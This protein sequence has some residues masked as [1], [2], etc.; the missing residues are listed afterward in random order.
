MVAVPHQPL[1]LLDVAGSSC[2]FHHAESGHLILERIFPQLEIIEWNEW[3]HEP[4]SGD[5]TLADVMT[6]RL[7][8]DVSLGDCLAAIRARGIEGPIV[9][10]LCAD[11]EEH[12]TESVK[13]LDNFILC[14]LR[15]GELRARLTQYLQPQSPQ[16]AVQLSSQI[17]RTVD[18]EPLIGESQSFKKVLER[19]ELI[20]RADGT[21]TKVGRTTKMG[22]ESFLMILSAT[23]EAAPCTPPR[24]ASPS[25]VPRPP[26]EGTRPRCTLSFCQKTT[27]DHLNRS[28]TLEK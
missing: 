27:S 18:E 17:K 8:D 3:W 13:S 20:A 9:A 16:S 14:P 23:R 15:E 26:A 11:Q 4:A 19:A 7:Q 25:S 6:I 24:I 2:H 10:F 28:L 21:T 5:V 12:W 1:I 22:R